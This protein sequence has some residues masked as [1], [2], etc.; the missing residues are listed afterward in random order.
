MSGDTLRQ[1][2]IESEWLDPREAHG[3]FRHVELTTDCAIMQVRREDLLN[4]PALHTANVFPQRGV[5]W[6]ARDF[7]RAFLSRLESREELFGEDHSEAIQETKDA[8]RIWYVALDAVNPI[9]YV[10]YRR[11]KLKELRELLGDDFHAGYMPSPVPLR[12]FRRID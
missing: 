10:T 9:Y 1:I 3:Y 8:L 5:C 2:S 11:H 4:A 12:F 6:D 7:G